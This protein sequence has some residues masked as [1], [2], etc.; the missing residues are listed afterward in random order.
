MTMQSVLW[1]TDTA[2]SPVNCCVMLR[3]EKLKYHLVEI[4]IR[5]FFWI[6]KRKMM[7]KQTR[8][9]TLKSYWN[10]QNRNYLWILLTKLIFHADT[11]IHES[12]SKSCCFANSLQFFFGY[13]RIF[14]SISR[15]FSFPSSDFFALKFHQLLRKC[16]QFEPI[17]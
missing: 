11:F 4:Y 14:D 3:G 2:S 10:E 8:T 9:H 6:T 12:K 17:W 13:I 16:F 5:I 7:N 1:M 15:I